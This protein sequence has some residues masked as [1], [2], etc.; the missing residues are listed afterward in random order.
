MTK[1]GQ[2]QRKTIPPPSCS[3]SISFCEMDLNRVG[4]W[5]PDAVR[6]LSSSRVTLPGWR[7]GKPPNPLVLFTMWPCHALFTALLRFLPFLLL[8]LELDCSRSQIPMATIQASA[9]PILL[10]WHC[11]VLLIIPGGVKGF[12]KTELVLIHSKFKNKC[13]ILWFGATGWWRMWVVS[14]RGGGS[15][16]K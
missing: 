13:I 4:S 16:I 2:F 11:R 14:K 8:F 6:I 10:L 9:F 5:Q 7:T 1:S 3:S 15:E 12:L